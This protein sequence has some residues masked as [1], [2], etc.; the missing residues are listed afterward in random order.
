VAPRIFAVRPARPQS[1]YAQSGLAL[2]T[3]SLSKSDARRACNQL[4]LGFKGS[5]IERMV[6]L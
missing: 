6:V 4:R 5:L 1:N 3:A 2:F